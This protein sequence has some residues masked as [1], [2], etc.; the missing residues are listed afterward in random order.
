VD[1]EPCGTDAGGG[2]VGLRAHARRSNPRKP[3]NR[4]DPITDQDGKRFSP[5][6]ERGELGEACEL[7]ADRARRVVVEAVRA[8][9]EGPFIPVGRV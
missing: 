5:R 3:T 4:A 1:E 8:L 7:A 9:G 6:A 2:L